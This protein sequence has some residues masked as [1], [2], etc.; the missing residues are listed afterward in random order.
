MYIFQFQRV[1]LERSS[2][3]YASI[4]DLFSQT[5]SGFRVTSIERVQNRGLW[6]VFQWYVLSKIKTMSKGKRLQLKK[7]KSARLLY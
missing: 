4:V 6:E 3:E 5:M 1:Q 2:K 7:K